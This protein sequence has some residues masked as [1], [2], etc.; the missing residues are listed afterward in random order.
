MRLKRLSLH[1]YKTFATK[2]DFEFGQGI[3]AIVGPNGC[4]KSNIADAIRWVL[5][6]QSY[7]TLRGHRTT[8]MIFAGSRSRTRAG[9]AQ[10]V[11]TLDNQERWLDIDYAEIEVG[12]R[13]YRSGENEYI[14]NQQ[15]VRLRD[16]NEL[17][18]NSGLGART[19]TIIGQGLVDQALS[20]RADER[21]A[22]FE[23][24]AGISHYKIKRAETIR[25]LDETKRNLERV[26]DIIAEIEPRLRSLK[27]QANRAKNY[28][29]VAADLHHHLRIWFGF[30]WEQ[31]RKELRAAREESEVAQDIWDTG[32]KSQLSIQREIDKLRREIS[33]L[34]RTIQD[35]EDDRETLRTKLEVANRDAAILAERLSFTQ[36]RLSE[37]EEDVPRLD[38]QRNFAQEELDKAILEF[39]SASKQL[40]IE[41][42][43]LLHFQERV[44][45]QESVI[46]KW[47]LTLSDLDRDRS[48][49]QA[50]INQASGS[51]EQ[52]R[53]RLAARQN[54]LLDPE[55]I[56]RIE[57]EVQQRRSAVG[58]LEE[59]IKVDKAMIADTEQEL[60][61]ISRQLLETHRQKEVIVQDDRRLELDRAKLDAQ[62]QIL[63]AVDGPSN[64]DLSQYS[65]I[66]GYLDELVA[67]PPKYEI[68]IRNAL[69]EKIRALVITGEA[70]LWD[71]AKMA[72][73]SS[74]I[75]DIQ[76]VSPHSRIATPDNPSVIGWANEYVKAEK[77]IS[78][79]SDLLL[80]RVLL[81][82]ADPSEAYTLAREL[83]SG[84]AVVTLDGLI[85]HAGGL[86]KT[87]AAQDSER[88]MQREELEAIRAE[89]G[90][91]ED[92]R[93]RFKQKAEEV[94]HEI[95]EL[96]K[97]KD[98]VANDLRLLT[99]STNISER[100]SF[101]S[102]HALE[103]IK[104]E[105][106][107]TS[108]RQEAIAGELHSLNNR[109]LETE[110]LMSEY[111]IT[112][113]KFESSIEHAN[114]ELKELPAAEIADERRHLEQAVEA[115]KTI[116][117][118]RQA[119]V[120][121][122]RATLLQ[123]DEQIDRISERIK[124]LRSREVD[125][126]LEE[127]AAIARRLQAEMDDLKTSLSPMQGSL[128]EMQDGLSTFENSLSDRLVNNQDAENRY[129]QARLALSQA[130]NRIDGLRERISTD[131]G[132]VDL[133]FDDDEI[134]QS[135][136]PMT[137]VVERLPLVD[138]LPEDIER[139][140][141]RFRGQLHRMGGINPEA[142]TEYE[143][144]RQR[145]EFLQK[146]VVDLNT[147]IEQLLEVIAELDE[148]TS[149]AF[150]ETVQR[151][152]EN[153]GEVFRRLFG[154]GTGRLVLTDPEQLTTTGVEIVA[155]LPNR[156]EQAL[157][158]LSGG[159]RSLT[160]TALIFSLLKV[161]PTPFCV[162]DEV[163]AMLDE[164]N[165][166]RFRELLQELSQDTQFIIITHN[167][168]TVQVAE[169]VYGVS[170]GADSASQVISI[171]PEEYV[172][173]AG[174][175]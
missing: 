93:L 114:I 23:E 162:L 85:V 81:I 136:L 133:P 156:R 97:N 135:P 51:L 3:T 38:R 168:G 113:T 165:V 92:L 103:S 11:L 54:E 35:K 154:G 67:V 27:I 10:A 167:R 7:S 126:H 146:Q 118:G 141:Q 111:S 68:A 170:M 28:E 5:G 155:R 134:A 106:Q 64:Y 89:I 108:I 169:S 58:G 117:A 109:I 40:N 142:P 110:K 123:I 43:S 74:F 128:R 84:S 47:E 73:A 107:S 60:K 20:L 48:D 61:K 13:A 63:E 145:H 83:P 59:A 37:I 69:A 66:V 9:M 57:D 152:D 102:R 115:A 55:E 140:I 15:K 30:H 46:D 138:D 99:E 158:L 33:G 39:D 151:V 124:D 159:E 148:L 96:Q 22:L 79:L 153:F 161:S 56:K 90:K 105:F 143:D 4:G 17:L 41:I 53:E 132:L 164:A 172:A 112:S 87:P 149:R 160:A 104:V 19:Y 49:T 175:N 75:A 2:T 21:R 78:N 127:R 14:L 88:T 70:E 122:R 144:T 120:D 121:S 131:L 95:V 25:H 119:V 50:Q 45:G 26:Y 44:R 16:V 52:L 125:M 157:G 29:H 8:D 1:G 174:I 36:R 77:S 130:E 62:R 76:S 24:A 147:T 100:K 129:L 31:T 18:A 94:E 86:V 34:V 72:P 82:A 91:N 139:T 173:V 71:L 12:R 150:V 116:V 6:E 32:R 171:K 137:D 65:S 101:E 80:G 98:N 163:D 166:N 42:N